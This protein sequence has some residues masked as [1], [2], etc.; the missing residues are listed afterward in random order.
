[1]ISKHEYYS[2]ANHTSHD[3]YWAFDAR[4]DETFQIFN[5]KYYTVL[6]ESRNLQ[7][8]YCYQLIRL[9]NAQSAMENT[10]RTQFYRT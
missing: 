10:I 4:I 3:R 1:M 8:M 7:D 9:T 2:M 5:Q 6:A